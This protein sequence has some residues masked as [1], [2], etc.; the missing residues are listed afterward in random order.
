LKNPNELIL[1]KS[2]KGIT[3]IKNSRRGKRGEIKKH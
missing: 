2:E 1:E 3:P